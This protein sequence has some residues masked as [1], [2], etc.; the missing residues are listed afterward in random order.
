MEKN[1]ETYIRRLVELDSR[2]LA[3]REERD[4]ELLELENRNR[5]E[6]KRIDAVLEKA[7]ELAK[8]RYDGIIEDARLKAREIDEET[9]LKAG[10]LQ[11]AFLSFREDAAKAVWRQLLEIER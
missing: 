11:A 2:A 1:M 5:D 8:Q 9:G 6:L 10:E 4:A 7:A 3:L